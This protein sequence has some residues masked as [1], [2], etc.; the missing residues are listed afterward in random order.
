M[1]QLRKGTGVDFDGLGQVERDPLAPW[2]QHLLDNLE[3]ERMHRQAFHRRRAGQQRAETL[4]PLTVEGALAPRCRS[5]T[6]IEIRLYRPEVRRVGKEADS[7]VKT[8]W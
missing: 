4:G 5:E 7:T 6:S 2:K 1:R 8:R 3:D